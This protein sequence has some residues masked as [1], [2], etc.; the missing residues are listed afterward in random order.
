MEQLT[1]FL[2][3]WKKRYNRIQSYRIRMWDDLL[4]SEVKIEWLIT[5]LTPHQWAID[6]I[7]RHML[8]SEIRYIHQ[9]FNA[10]VLQIE[11]A[12][13]TQW[14]NKNFFRII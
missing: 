14:V 11:E 1:D 8:A 5:R 7:I 12:V 3:L 10:D 9:I 13:G 6:E 2:S 4:N